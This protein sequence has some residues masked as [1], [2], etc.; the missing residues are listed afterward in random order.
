[1][2][3]SRPL[4][5]KNN[6]A[7]D[8]TMNRYHVRKQMNGRI[9]QRA[10]P[11]KRAAMMF[12]EALVTDAIAAAYGLE[13]EEAP[14]TLE[15]VFEEYIAE[16]QLYGRSEETI[17]SYR[18]ASVGIFK[19]IGKSHSPVLTKATV[20]DYVRAR[21]QDGA[22]NRA[23]TTELK[24][25]RTVVR[26]VVGESALTWQLPAL[27]VP[28]A[29]KVLPPDAEIRAVWNALAGREDIRTAIMLG[30]LTGMRASDVLRAG[31]EW[32]DGALLAVPMQKRHGLVNVVPLVPTLTAR[33]DALHGAH[34]APCTA[35]SIKMVL[36]RMTR[37]RKQREAPPVATVR[38]WHGIG[39]LRHICAT[40]AAQA[41]HDEEGVGMVLG[42]AGRSVARR[43][44]ITDEGI[45]IKR[46]VL[47][48]VEKRWLKVITVSIRRR[49]EKGRNV[50]E[51]SER[52]VRKCL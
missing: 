38:P 18:W 37:P 17:H 14:K 34:Y 2:V 31:P 44:Y 30:V 21:Q 23:I 15:D 7:F 41:G 48:S 1:M 47:E 32:R 49:S 51:F 13:I 12:L 39:H 33:L 20:N 25:L 27:A 19:H 24:L 52:E 22:S 29:A 3:R 35:S 9:V 43:H 40:W 6:I 10:F 16:R 42:H 50:L 36:Q 5:F 11:T 45:D 28:P 46:K 26:H 4:A 8:K